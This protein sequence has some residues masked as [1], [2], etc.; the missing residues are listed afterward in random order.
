LTTCL[1][2]L[3]CEAS[4]QGTNDAVKNAVI[5]AAKTGS[6]NNSLLTFANNLMQIF[7]TTYDSTAQKA[8]LIGSSLFIGV[9]FLTGLVYTIVV[10]MYPI[11]PNM[12]SIGHSAMHSSETEDRSP[13][14]LANASVAA[15]FGM[16]ELKS[17]TAK[18]LFIIAV[19]F[20]PFAMSTLMKFIL[21]GSDTLSPWN[22]MMLFLFVDPVLS[23]L[24]SFL[25]TWNFQNILVDGKMVGSG[26]TRALRL[27]RMFL[28]PF[29]LIPALLSLNMFLLE[30]QC[31]D[32]TVTPPVVGMVC[33]M[34][35]SA[36]LLAIKGI[37]GYMFTWSYVRLD[38]TYPDESILRVSTR[39]NARGHPTK[40]YVV[41]G[42]L[43]AVMLC[44]WFVYGYYTYP[45]QI[46]NVPFNNT[47]KLSAGGAIG[48][49]IALFAVFLLMCWGLYFLYQGQLKDPSVTR[50]RSEARV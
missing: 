12:T 17:D 48:V 45:N 46:T 34:E 23:T 37:I 43:L 31:I 11:R 1:I 21:D 14:F 19:N 6:S 41:T 39:A 9:L 18:V 24:A 30:T 16:R 44:G 26:T 47:V 33:N 32:T 4:L 29:A 22:S 7:Q 38:F 20:L 10:Y 27:L 49:C 5:V 35:V 36:V 13:E 8:M 25:I 40:H 28:V 3:S 42:V 2:F 15:Q 50:T